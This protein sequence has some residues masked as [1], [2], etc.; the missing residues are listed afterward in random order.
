MYIHINICIDIL[1]QEVIR[2]PLCL[3]KKLA[4]YSHHQSQPSQLLSYPVLRSLISCRSASAAI[5]L[6]MHNRGS[7]A[8]ELV[9]VLSQTCMTYMYVYIH[10]RIYI[11]I[12]Q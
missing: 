9:G 8:W 1:I 4:P 6:P 3:F 11:Y 2:D 7:F 10:I 5:A 12:Y